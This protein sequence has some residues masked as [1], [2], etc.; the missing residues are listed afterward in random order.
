MVQSLW[1]HKV[2]KNVSA[3]YEAKRS[4]GDIIDYLIKNGANIYKGALVTTTDANGY[5]YAGADS[6]SI[7]FQGIAVEKSKTTDVTTDADGARHVRVFK[8]GVFELLATGTASQAWVGFK[9]YI[10]DDNTV[11]LVATTS[12]DCHCGTCVEFIDATHVR[13]KIDDAAN[14]GA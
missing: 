7:T 14:Q 5:L 2:N 13:V 9:V 1:R 4:D 8:T 11:A 10:S 12:N 6:A 3:D